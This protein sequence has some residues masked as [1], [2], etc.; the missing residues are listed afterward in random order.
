MGDLKKRWR[1][2]N[3]Q[4]V[5]EEPH[6]CRDVH[7]CSWL[8]GICPAGW[9]LLAGWDAGGGVLAGWNTGGGVLAGWDA[10]G[11]RLAGWD[12]GGGR[13]VAE[14]DNALDLG[15]WHP[16]LHPLYANHSGGVIPYYIEDGEGIGAHI[17]PGPPTSRDVWR[18]RKVLNCFG[19]K[20]PPFFFKCPL[21]PSPPPPWH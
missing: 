17:R 1:D 9:E 13:L 3:S 11:G 8:S 21:R 6:T 19:L 16:T 2:L 20:V 12:A 14:F 10:G 15:S 18:P 7:G 5:E 4:A